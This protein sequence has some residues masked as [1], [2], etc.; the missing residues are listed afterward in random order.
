METLL[1]F[2]SP[3]GVVVLALVVVY[4]SIKNNSTIKNI[5]DNHLS[6]LPDMKDT[7]LR[8]EEKLEKINDTLMQIKGG[9]K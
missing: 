2:A 7:L 8:I 3:M 4:Q 9:L 6:G 1:Q 5:G